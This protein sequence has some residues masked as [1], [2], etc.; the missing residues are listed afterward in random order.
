MFPYFYFEPSAFKS[1]NTNYQIGEGWTLFHCQREKFMEKTIIILYTSCMHFFKILKTLKKERKK[2]ILSKSKE[3]PTFVSWVASFLRKRCNISRKITFWNTDNN[4]THLNKLRKSTE[5]L[6]QEKSKVSRNDVSK[7]FCFYLTI[8]T[9]LYIRL[10]IFAYDWYQNW[11]I[12]WST[13]PNKLMLGYKQRFFFEKKETYA[14]VAVAIKAEF[15]KC[16]GK[17][18]ATAVARQFWQ[19]WICLTNKFADAFWLKFQWLENSRV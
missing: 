11:C 15:T 14:K 8:K 3:N 5:L 13:T 1:T 10:K 7:R 2:W 12:Q 18:I 9:I 19:F 4:T 17:T 6:P 16:V